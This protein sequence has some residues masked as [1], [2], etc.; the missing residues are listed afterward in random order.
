[1]SK[2]YANLIKHGLKTIDQVPAK[3]RADVIECLRQDVIDGKITVEEFEQF[4]GQTYE[5][6]E[7]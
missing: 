6:V 5:V 1:M 2:I 7:E 4:T 3:I